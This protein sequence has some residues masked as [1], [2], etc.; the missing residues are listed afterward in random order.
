MQEG[1]RESSQPNLCHE[2]EGED[3]DIIGLEVSVDDVLLVEVGQ[4]AH[5]LQ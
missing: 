2:T 4:S 5:H 1:E 3:E